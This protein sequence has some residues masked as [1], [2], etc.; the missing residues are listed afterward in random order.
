MLEQ[1][2]QEGSTPLLVTPT[3]QQWDTG[4]ESI[5]WF[6]NAYPAITP[7][8][9]RQ[10]ARSGPGPVLAYVPDFGLLHLAARY[11]RGSALA[12]VETT[13]TP[14]IGW[15]METGAIN[16]LTG[17]ATPDTLRDSQR[18]LLERVHRNGNNGWTRGFGRDQTLR[19]LRGAY[20]QDGLTKD[21]IL[22]TMAA[23]GHNGKA[24]ERLDE[25]LDTLA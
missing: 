16:L 3:Q 25:V 21:I 1:A 12:V 24:V 20:G 5:T 11:A 22:G 23:K 6:A 7:R 2:K 15:A 4:G 18:E 14:L 9:S 17:Q 13:S 19:A 10:R 8:S